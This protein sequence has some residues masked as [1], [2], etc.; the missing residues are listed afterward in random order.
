MLIYKIMPRTDWEN[1]TDAY[2]GSADDKRDG[3]IHFSTHAQ[4]A[5][6][7]AK[8]YA[9]Q[10]GLMLLAIEADDLGA[11]LKWELAPKRGEEFPHLYAALSKDKVVWAKP[12][13]RDADGNFLLPPEQ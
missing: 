6:T 9:G 3:F 5:G 2:H 1:V 8:H 7:L 13:N 4:L 11:A 10:T 12:L